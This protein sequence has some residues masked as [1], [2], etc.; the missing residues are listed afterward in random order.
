MPFLVPIDI[1]KKIE[2]ESKKLQNWGNCLCNPFFFGL[3]NDRQD[4]FD[5]S[6][7]FW[8]ISPKQIEENQR[9]SQIISS[10]CFPSQSHSLITKMV[11]W[12]F[13]TTNDRTNLTH[14][15]LIAFSDLEKRKQKSSRK[16]ITLAHVPTLNQN[17]F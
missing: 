15:L 17:P 13:T 5:K 14:R 8:K 9:Q 7:K 11:F 2:E 1:N 16:K 3:L 10:D 12:I 6:W 4:K